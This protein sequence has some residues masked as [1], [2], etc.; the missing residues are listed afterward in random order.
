M[1][2]AVYVFRFYIYA[3][4]IFI[5]LFC[6]T[7]GKGSYQHTPAFFYLVIYFIQ[8]IINLIYGWAHFYRRVQQAGRP[9]YLL[10]YYATAFFKLIISRCGRYIHSLVGKVFKFMKI[11]WPVIH[12]RWQAE[13]IINQ[14]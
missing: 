1:H 12:G 4:Q 9:H 7:F 10:Y 3:L 14:Y 13:T 6:H 2:F 11:L 5:H 8:Q